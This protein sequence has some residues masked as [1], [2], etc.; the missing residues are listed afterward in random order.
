MLQF[1]KPL[2][3]FLNQNIQNSLLRTELLNAIQQEHEKILLEIF[4]TKPATV[5]SEKTPMNYQI[6][7]QER[8]KSKAK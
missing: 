3:A 1:L 4:K 5:T 6:Y 2:R 8:Y 7:R